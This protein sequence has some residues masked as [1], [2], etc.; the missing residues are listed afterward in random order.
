MRNRQ[1][2]PRLRTLRSRATVAALLL[3][4]AAMSLTPGAVFASA[5]QQAPST[6]GLAALQSSH[7]TSLGSPAAAASAHAA[8]PAHVAAAPTPTK[9]PKAK[10]SKRQAP[11]RRIKAA[12]PAST[13]T[14]A[15]NVRSC[16]LYA[17]TG[18][19][20]L[21]GGA[22]VN[23]WGFSS[24]SA[25]GSE[26]LPGPVLVANQGETLSITLHNVN[27]PSATS[28]AL[29]Q[30]SAVPDT[31][32]VTAG[33]ATTYSFTNVQPGTYL[34]EAGLT[35]N[36][37]R[38]AAMG[39]FGA[40]VVR[41][42]ACS[43]CAYDATSTFDDEAVLVLS[44]LDPAFNANPLS[45]N[46]PDYAPK[47]WLING[48]AYPNTVGIATDIGHKVLLRYVN[49]G[50]KPH[51][52][53]VL[54][55]HQTIFGTDAKPVTNP[56]RVV[57]Q[58]VPAG[59]SLDTIAT[60]P[61][62]AP[63][64]SSF[65][66]YDAATHLDNNGQFTAPA[67]PNSAISVGGML[68]YLQVAGALSPGTAPVTSQVSL[69]PTATNGSTT[70][71]LNATAQSSTTT[72]SA[73]EYFIDNLGANGTGTLM[74]GTFGTSS[75]TVQQDVTSAVA[76]LPSGIHTF[77]V[78]AQDANGQWG[79]VASA[80]LNVDK[81]GPSMSGMTLT[82]NPT[83]GKSDVK[84]LATASDAAT[85]NQNVVAAEYFID[86]S[87][88]PA[89]GSGTALS[90]TCTSGVTPPC[91]A[92]TVS[93]SVTIPVASLPGEGAHTVAV[94]AQDALGNWGPFGTIALK[95]DKTGPNTSGLTI[96]PSPTNG[97]WG[98]PVV[99]SDAYYEVVS[100][101]FSDPVVNGANSNIAA[102]EYFIDT[103]GANGSGQLMQ[104]ASASYNSPN[105]SGYSWI[106][107]WQIA[108]LSEGQHTVYV[109]AKDAAGNWGPF[110]TTTFIVDKTG[111]TISNAAVTA[112]NAQNQVTLTAT[113]TDPADTTGTPAPAPAS[114]VI[115]AEWF[116]GTDPGQGNGT[117]ITITTPAPSVSLSA[118]FTVQGFPAI[119]V[120]TEDAA[121]NWGPYVTVFV[122]RPNAIFSDGF[123]SGNFSAWSAIGGTA[124]RISVVANTATHPSQAGPYFMQAAISSGTSGYVQDNSPTAETTYHA[125][126]YINP[127]GVTLGTTTITIFKGLNGTN[128][129]V[130]A[131][132]LR[133]S[134]GV[135][136]VSLAVTSVNGT[137]TSSW[138]ALTGGQWNSVEIAWQS[139]P[140][141]TVSLY[142]NNTNSSAPNATISPL[143]TSAQTLETVQLGPQ[144]TLSG[145]SGS[146]YFDSFAS[147][148]FTFI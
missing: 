57:A 75:V 53:S 129:T 119:S 103:P 8:A 9:A 27:V 69:Q 81:T 117:P 22:T 50:L 132:L 14:L 18:T 15:S 10:P 77:F 85:G 55:L 45:F 98:N 95:I 138:V 142:V 39:L 37:P 116:I 6:A 60:I 146:I 144:G 76:P 63:T 13:C 16:D 31:T 1:L 72:V 91:P 65:A 89:G 4:I 134:G 67:D 71:M 34:Y 135:Y 133:K 145:V 51:S 137:S 136:Q 47:Y 124:G 82:P 61:S 96:L 102:A 12:L 2:P 120:R 56:M 104:P 97:Q 3:A 118:T 87:G 109:N 140:A 131:V 80:V 105:S 101:N 83:D 100:A 29:S 94:R 74:S 11:V 54:G 79:D 70:E 139:A 41:P 7:A 20:A 66:L 21:P 59:S 35:A 23:I 64:G 123:D 30:A 121:H 44:E 78:H 36:G 25:A 58:T 38:E 128:G 84:L 26:T 147:T 130:F 110:A 42:T 108:A 125:R 40:L 88:T 33:N 52:M 99:G 143:D 148:R 111:P 62:N 86:P 127:H 114:N 49:A 112:P 106:Q 141:A 93:L 126:F 113:A 32:G 73:M 48:A 122:P 46:M 24:S 28:L 19:L 107:L 92:P 115:A 43:N 17:M 90:F 68:T 5:P